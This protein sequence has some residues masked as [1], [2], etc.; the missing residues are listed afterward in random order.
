M[1][2]Q[3]VFTE[4]FENGSIAYIDTDTDTAL[5]IPSSFI[6]SLINSSIHLFPRL[7]LQSHKASTVRYRV[8]VYKKKD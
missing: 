7:T 6:H 2:V 3:V 8:T 5:Q 4:N 1:T